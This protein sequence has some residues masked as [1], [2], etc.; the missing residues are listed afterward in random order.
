MTDTNPADEQATPAPP[1]LWADLLGAVP[2]ITGGACTE[3]YMDW[4]RD[5]ERNPSPRHAHCR[6]ALDGDEVAP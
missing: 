2:D 4:V 3:C 6:A 5:R 1:P